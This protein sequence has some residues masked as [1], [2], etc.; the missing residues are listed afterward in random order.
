MDISGE[1]NFIEKD[2]KKRLIIAGIKELEENGLNGFSYRRVANA[3]GISCATPYRHFKDLSQFILEIINYINSK[4]DILYNDLKEIFETDQKRFIIELITSTV[5]FFYANPNY[6]AVMFSE[7]ADKD[8]TR[9]KQKKHVGD[10]ISKVIYEFCEKENAN[11]IDAVIFKTCSLLYGAI[12][13]TCGL[14]DQD[15]EKAIS[16]LKDALL[17]II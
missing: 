4:W 5:R 12:Y 7:L 6:R 2:V 1:D 13:L 17:S 14:N 8:E 11:N 15:T 9:N 16:N 10:T 3:C